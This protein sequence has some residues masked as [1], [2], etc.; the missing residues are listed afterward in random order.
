M[1]KQRTPFTQPLLQLDT[2]R[3]Q[4]L[5]QL[6]PPQTRPTEMQ[7]KIAAPIHPSQFRKWLNLAVAAMLGLMGWGGV[8]WGGVECQHL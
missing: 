2:E 1:V 8:G 5:Q 7:V 3:L 4:L 6:S